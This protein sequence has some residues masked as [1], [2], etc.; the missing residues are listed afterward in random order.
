MS[1]NDIQ[2]SIS[3]INQFFYQSYP[4]LGVTKALDNEEFAYFSEFHKVWEKH[5]KEILNPK[6]D[7]SQCSLVADVLHDVFVK[8]KGRPFTEL[9]DTYSLKPKEVCRIRY[10]SANQDFRGTRDFE[11]LFKK[12]K[13]DPSIFDIKNI[14]QNPEDFLKNIGITGLS[15]SDKRVKYAITA[16]QILIDN[17]IEPYDFLSFCNNDI[18]K[19]RNLLIDNRGSGFGNK[20]TD[21]FLRDMVVLGVWKN[22]KNFDKIDVASDINTTKVALRSRILKTDIILISSFLDIFCYQYGL[23]DQMNALAWR[24]V[25]EIWNHKYP[26]EC[27]ESPCLI[28]YFVYKVIG[29]DFCKESLCIFECE[30]KKHTFKWH[31]GRNKTCQVCFKNNTKNKANILNKVLPCSDNDGYIAIE[32][33]DFVSGR[34]PLLPNLKECPFVIVC[35]PKTKMFRKLN[36]PKSISIL[37]QTGWDSARATVD[38]GGG[39]LMS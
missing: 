38:E 11:N 20:K 7:E 37:G 5:H 31:S 35:N 26:D 22:P 18:E 8:Y 24:K 16:S 28:D 4:E 3:K 34:E 14:N 29:K 10:F 32:Q 6:V 25:W 36:P 2:S 27:V 13:D 19:V 21:M 30:T 23:I 39:G 15:Q 12:Y 9:Y 33:S 1:L 17:K